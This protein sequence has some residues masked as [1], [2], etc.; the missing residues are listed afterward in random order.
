MK[1]RFTTF[2]MSVIIILIIAVLALFGILIYSEITEDRIK[3]KCRKFCL[4]SHKFRKRRKFRNT[5]LYRKRLK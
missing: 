3:N 4:N 5:K 2:I 1:S